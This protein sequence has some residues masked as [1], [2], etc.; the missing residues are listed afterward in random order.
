MVV[1]AAGGNT[2][3]NLLCLQDMGSPN[4]AQA[5][6][7]P[8]SVLRLMKID[9]SINNSCFSYVMLLD[10]GC[11]CGVCVLRVSDYIS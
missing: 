9:D 11:C 10:F 2:E 8:V 5:F 1:S 7:S 3:G 4:S 6:L